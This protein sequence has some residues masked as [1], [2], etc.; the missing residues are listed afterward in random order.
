MRPRGDIPFRRWQAANI[1]FRRP[2]SLLTDF[3]TTLLGPSVP[4]VRIFLRAGGP[5]SQYPRVAEP[6]G[7]MH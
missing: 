2:A 7:R 6:R 3:S 5:R 1:Q 4:P